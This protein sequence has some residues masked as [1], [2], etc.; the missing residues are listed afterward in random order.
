[1]SLRS[2]KFSVKPYVQ[3]FFSQ[4][5]SRKGVGAKRLIEHLERASFVVMKKPPI[6]GG[7]ALARGF[8]ADQFGRTIARPCPAMAR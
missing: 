5:V 6:G 7:A 3:R 2:R 8:E 4:K 1:M